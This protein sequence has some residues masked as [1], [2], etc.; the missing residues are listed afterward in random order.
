VIFLTGEYA[1]KIK[2]PV[3]FDFLDFR[4]LSNRRQFCME[5]VRLNARL[6]PDMYLGV[7]PIASDESGLHVAGE[8]API[9]WAVRMRQLDPEQMLSDRLKRSVVSNRDIQKIAATLADFHARS[10]STPEIR[11]W[12]MHAV[13][14]R[15]ILNVLDAMDELAE[16]LVG[17]DARQQIRAYS[18]S[19]LDRE[20]PLFHRRANDGSIRDCHGDLRAQNICLDPRFSNGI[21]IFVC[22]EFNEE[23]R[24]I[25]VAADLAYL[26]MDL[27][28]AGRPDLRT[29][30]IEEYCR[31]RADPDLLR[32]LPFY[33][34]YR[35]CVRGNIALFA[36]NE[37]EIPDSQREAH[38][39][40]AAAAYDLARCC[41]AEAGPSLFIMIGFS[42]S[43]KSALARELSRRLPAVMISTDEVREQVEKD[44]PPGP[45][46][47]D[48]YAPARRA[49]V[50]QELYR[51]A[52][53]HLSGGLNVVLDGTFLSPQERE[54]AA[55]LALRTSAQFCMIECQ[56]PNSVIRRRLALRQARPTDS[57]AGVAVYEQQAASFA[58]VQVPAI[59][60]ALHTRH[61]IV[62]TEQ[63]SQCAAHD[64][65]D[66]FTAPQFTAA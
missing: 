20:S 21:Q 6:C 42:G 61:L 55:R 30:L 47:G 9:E 5:E 14:S 66:R 15:S 34:T 24:C 49:E 65:V 16:D 53:P 10:A 22:I 36:A 8:G 43:G 7:V 63:P 41:A 29:L 32:L 13:V 17:A 11:D 50:Y 33:Q 51:R 60:G 18:K 3:R 38:R 59:D 64:V 48:R 2:K 1:Y 37:H 28:L 57:D 19:F 44:R 12:G 27:D 56:C 39:E 35:A 4:F 52:E 26:A 54:N 62:D 46:A 45:S 58:P 31:H 23:F 40:T 25:D